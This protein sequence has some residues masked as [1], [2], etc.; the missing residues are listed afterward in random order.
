MCSECGSLEVRGEVW[1]LFSGVWVFVLVM[2][3]LLG[4]FILLRLVLVGERLFVSRK[5][6][7]I[8]V[9]FIKVLY[10]GLYVFWRWFRVYFFFGIVLGFGYFVNV[11]FVF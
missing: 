5:E 4:F 6:L 2:W 10:F 11:F 1:G 9:V 8:R 7:V 3:G